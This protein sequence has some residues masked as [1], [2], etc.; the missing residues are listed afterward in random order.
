MFRTLMV[1]V[2]LLCLIYPGTVMAADASR[3]THAV[4]LAGGIGFQIAGAQLEKQAQESYDT[5]LHT[6][7]PSEMQ[8]LTDEYDR[9]HLQSVI[10]SKTGVGMIGLA[11]FLALTEQFRPV[12]NVE[13]SFQP[14]EF[15]IA[16]HLARR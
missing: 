11:V 3:I 1:T 12:K 5:Y 10:F 16:F 15:R 6:G 8:R 7:L 2:V 13:F 4:L 14:R 9:K